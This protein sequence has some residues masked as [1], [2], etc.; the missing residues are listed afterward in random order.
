MIGKYP[1]VSA[2]DAVVRLN[3]QFVDD[4]MA[5]P[6]PYPAI[7]GGDTPVS[8]TES[9]TDSEMVRVEVTLVEVAVV[10]SPIWTADGFTVL[11]PHYRF[12]DT[13]GQQWWVAAVTDRYL[14]G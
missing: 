6:L 10:L 8:N 11:A 14:A 7:D 1:T 5:R 12:T 4:G 3:T 9:S 13:D 2:S